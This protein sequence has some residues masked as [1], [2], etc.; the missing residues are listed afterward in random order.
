MDW[1]QSCQDWGSHVITMRTNGNAVTNTNQQTTN[2]PDLPKL[3]AR[4]E[5]MT[6]HVTTE[7]LTLHYLILVSTSR[8]L[9]CSPTSLDNV[10]PDTLAYVV[11][12]VKNR[13][14]QDYVD[15]RDP[16]FWE[17]YVFSVDLLPS[18]QLP[19]SLIVLQRRSLWFAASRSHRF[20]TWFA[21]MQR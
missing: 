18:Q 5:P 2:I 10:N 8:W 7:L 20:H 21:N 9:T 13:L 1:G 11:K 16:R 19:L 6:C 17:V 3:P 14:T 4:H 15:Q 12:H